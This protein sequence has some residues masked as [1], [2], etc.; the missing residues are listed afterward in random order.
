MLKD[1]W[2]GD[3]IDPSNL[4]LNKK[5]IVNP[6]AGSLSLHEYHKKMFEMILSNV[7]R[8]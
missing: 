4:E 2:I 7:K 3:P 8:S 6:V 1:N 5:D